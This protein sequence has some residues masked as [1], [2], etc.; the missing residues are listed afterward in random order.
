[1]YKVE[2]DFTYKGYR[3][4][5]IFGDR[6]ISAQIGDSRLYFLERELSLLEKF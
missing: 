2:S 6:V 1:M 5:V 4:V 3:C